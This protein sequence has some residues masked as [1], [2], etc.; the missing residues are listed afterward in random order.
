MR[1]SHINVTISSRRFP[2]AV[3][4]LRIPM[5]IET[6]R[7]ILE[8]ESIFNQVFCFDKYQLKVVNKGLLLDEGCY[9]SS[10]PLADGDCLEIMEG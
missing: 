5:A 4:D 9:L 2:E 1:P 10:Y 3:Y 6:R 8:L 7:L